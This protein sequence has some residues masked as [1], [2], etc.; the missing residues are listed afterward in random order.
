MEYSTLGTTKNVLKPQ[1][2]SSLVIVI[3]NLIKV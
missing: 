1:N 3:V 2:F